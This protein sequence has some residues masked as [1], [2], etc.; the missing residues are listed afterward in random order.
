MI[1]QMEK[2]MILKEID[3]RIVS[4]ITDAT[5]AKCEYMVVIVRFVAIDSDTNKCTVVQRILDVVLTSEHH[6]AH[7]AAGTSL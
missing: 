2:D 7:K 6:D 3:G 1:S 4:M 5:N